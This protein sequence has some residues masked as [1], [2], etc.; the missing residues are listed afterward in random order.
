MSPQLLIDQELCY[1]CSLC[2]AVCA[3][4]AL[5]LHP[6]FLSVDLGL[7]TLCADCTIACPTSALCLAS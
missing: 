5:L 2:V 1:Q 3:D 6:H 7:C 4:D